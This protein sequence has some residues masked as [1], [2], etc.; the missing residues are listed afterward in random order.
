MIVFQYQELV[1]ILPN[2]ELDDS[3][4][5]DIQTTFYRNMAGS[6]W[7]Y[8]KTP[9]SRTLNLL[10]RSLSRTR[11]LELEY[12]IIQTAGSTIQ[13]TDFRNQV[14]SGSIVNSPIDII[15]VSK[16]QGTEDRPEATDV[17]IIFK[18]VKL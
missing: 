7:S 5:I 12:F 13:Y 15:T 4:E 3:K 18:G 2:P 6:I 9:A 11:A 8:I 16:G 14:W 17:S 1:V 10:F